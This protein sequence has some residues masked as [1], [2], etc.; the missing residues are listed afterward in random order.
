MSPGRFDRKR[1]TSKFACDRAAKPIT[2]GRTTS[3]RNG[4]I[5]IG[6]TIAFERPTAARSFPMTARTAVQLMGV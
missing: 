6:S 4:T 1:D 3:I 2:S 5:S